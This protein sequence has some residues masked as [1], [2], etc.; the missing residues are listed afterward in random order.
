[1]M[2]ADNDIKPILLG[3]YAA[4]QCAVRT[5]NDHLPIARKWVPS[6]EDQARLDAG[7]AFEDEVFAQLVALHPAAVCI[8]SQMRREEAIEATMAAMR[9]GAPIILGGWLPDDEAGGR[10]GRPDILVAVQGG[11]LPADV[12]HHRSA[13]PKE[14]KSTVVA[15]LSDP[16]DWR[17]VSGWSPATL[18]RY[19]DG[20]QLAHYSRSLLACGAH[21]GEHRMWGAILGTTDIALSEGGQPEPVFVWH[22]LAAPAGYTFSRSSDTGKRRRSLLERYDHEHGFR[23]RVAHAARQATRTGDMTTLLVEPVGQ[24]ECAKCPYSEVCAAQMGPDDPSAAITVG[25]LDTREWLT[26]R[27][28]GITTTAD[29]AEVDSADPAF[30]DSYAREVSHRGRD[31]VKT[32]LDGAIRRAQMI[33]AGVGVIRI[34]DDHPA[35]AADVEID[36]DIEWD[37]AGRTY[38]WGARI[39]HRSAP[40]AATYVAFTDW[41]PTFDD[42]AERELAGRCADWIRAQR[43]AAQAAGRSVQVFHWSSPEPARLRKILGT[44]ATA[45]LLN[46]DRG[47]FVDLEETFKMG[48]LSLHGTSIKKVAPIFGFSWSAEDAGGANSQNYLD[49]VRAGGPTAEEAKRWLLD[50]NLDDCAAMAAIRDGMAAWRE[51]AENVSAA[52]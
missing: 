8:E 25:N 48:Y 24:G 39:R 30:F 6:S 34:A 40:A 3:G 47:I 38:L 13:E 37:T 46:P 5:Q 52:T 26:L 4:K 35:P 36:L 9:A 11:Y 7:I 19:S 44:D 14:R 45:D 16:A 21:P 1:M 33:R 23:V 18:Y 42:A 29:L 43:A 12:K 41:S 27:R 17:P 28:L 51:P 22:D 15:P 2:N 10:K 49:A 50:Y 20:L 32:R 31:H